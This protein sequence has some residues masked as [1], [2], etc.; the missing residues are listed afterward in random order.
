P[1]EISTFRNLQIAS[2]DKKAI[3]AALE[4]ELEDDLPFESDSLHYDSVIL[5][6]GPAGSSIH[7]GA[8]KK[9]TFQNYLH[10]L[11]QAGLDPDIVTTDAWAY[12]CLIGRILGNRTASVPILLLGLERDKTF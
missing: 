5:N 11:L 12:R 4:F 8:V 1:V 6:S 3:R 9:D 10:G 2:K 7:V